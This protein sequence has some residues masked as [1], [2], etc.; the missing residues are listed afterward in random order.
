MTEP[1]KAIVIG[2][3][4]IDLVIQGLPHF[5]QPD[6]Q[7]NGQS[8]RLSPGG[9]GRNI[10]AMLAPWMAPGQV[11]MISKLVQDA[12]GLYKIPLESLKSAG[13]N[14]DGIRL[15]TNRPEDLP[16]LSIFLNQTSGQRASY[17]L[18][19]CNETLTPAEILQTRPLLEKLAANDGILLMTLEMPLETAAFILAM[20]HDLSLPVML[21]PGGQPPEAQVDFTPLFIHP[22]KWIKPNA[23]EAE[24]ITGI[25]VESFEDAKLAAEVMLN[26]GVEFVLITDGARGAYAFTL[27]NSI[28]LPPPE[29][30][31]PIHAESTG[32]G[33][34]VLAVLC[35][36]TLA[37]KALY[38]AAE[39]AV[40]AGTLQFIQDGMYPILPD[41]LNLGN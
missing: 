30:P 27:N 31:I 24:R 40:R 36:Q 5:A 7:V 2:A 41:N 39:F 10:A 29:M 23:Q 28:I 37:G 15:E 35:A 34:Q 20:A 38:S 33:D 11:G 1:L 19:G 6:E 18:P 25:Q 22:P 26:K 4:N 16:T 17:Y 9:K 12:Q 21:D 13:V 8:V 32:C 14:L 3:L